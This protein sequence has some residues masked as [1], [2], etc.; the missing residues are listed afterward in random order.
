M[1]VL[2]SRAGAARAFLV[3][4]DLA[5]GGR[6][7]RIAWAPLGHR[8]DVGRAHV[9]D[10]RSAMVC[11]A[12]FQYRRHKA[13]LAGAAGDAL[14]QRLHREHRDEIEGEPALR[15]LVLVLSWR[16]AIGTIECA[17]TSGSDSP[18]RTPDE[19]HCTHYP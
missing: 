2:I 6:I 1:T 10:L 9:A 7:G 8:G 3:A 14:A 13:A 17:G 15:L 4:A 12:I 16:P 11:R 5:P 19:D 18:L